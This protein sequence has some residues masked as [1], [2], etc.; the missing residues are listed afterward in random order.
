MISLSLD[1]FHESLLA[2]LE[3]GLMTSR[4]IL[5]RFCVIDESSRRSPAYLD[6]RYSCFYYHLGKYI[7]P[8]SILEMGFDIGLLSGS[9]LVS[10]KTPKRFLGFRESDSD[11]FSLRLGQRN[12]RTVMRGLRDYHV[13]SLYDP[14]LAA[15]ID[16]GTWDLALVTDFVTEERQLDYLEYI[17]P[18][19]SDNGI[20]VCENL[21]GK[22]F[23]EDN[24]TGFCE[25]KNRS[26]YIFPTR[27]GTGLVQK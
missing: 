20:I 18:H 27:Y 6:G 26:A 15:K 1:E 23:S 5:D 10:C 19:I 17:W 3:W 4:T 8:G 22:K 21:G 9:L 16:V 7:N 13:G 14:Q 2:D 24:F 25:S 11:Y 12:I